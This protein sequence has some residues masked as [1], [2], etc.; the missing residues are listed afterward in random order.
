MIAEIGALVSN[1]VTIGKMPRTE[2]LTNPIQDLRK[3]GHIS[4]RR[5]VRTHE[6]RDASSGGEEQVCALCGES[7]FLE[8]EKEVGG[9][10]WRDSVAFE[11]LAVWILPA[12]RV[13]KELRKVSL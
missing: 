3:L 13:K 2:V 12:A 10:C 8:E 4:H 5:S 1:G 11:A 7:E 6:R 9:I